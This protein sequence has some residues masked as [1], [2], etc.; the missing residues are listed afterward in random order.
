[1]GKL[2]IGFVDLGQQLL[3]G[4]LLAVSGGRAEGLLAMRIHG[5]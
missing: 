2:G 1:M 5:A 4:E 3:Q